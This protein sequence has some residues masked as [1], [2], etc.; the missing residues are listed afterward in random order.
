[1]LYC[2]MYKGLILKTVSYIFKWSP[3]NFVAPATCIWIFDLC[4]HACGV[5]TPMHRKFVKMNQKLHSVH[6][7]DYQSCYW[8]FE[9]LPPSYV[10]MCSSIGPVVFH[11]GAVVP[12]LFPTVMLSLPFSPQWNS[13]IDSFF[14]SFSVCFSEWKGDCF[15][16]TSVSITTVWPLPLWKQ[17]LPVY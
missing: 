5:R 4:W 10:T 1:M 17:T 9:S 13:C 6:C 16:E 14:L 3:L 7:E 12:L 8:L 15:L 2:I 11:C